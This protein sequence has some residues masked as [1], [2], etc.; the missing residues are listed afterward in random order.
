M[1]RVE[2]EYSS[3]E[4]RTISIAC[5]SVTVGVLDGTARPILLIRRRKEI[6]CKPANKMPFAI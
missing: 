2:Y 1:I 4:N 6:E 3:F 5:C